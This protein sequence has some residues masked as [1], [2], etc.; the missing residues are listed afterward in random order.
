M[1][2]KNQGLEAGMGMD[3]GRHQIMRPARDSVGVDLNFG[4]A[5]ILLAAILATSATLHG[6][7]S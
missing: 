1:R 6:C 3:F 5:A 4:L 7:H 2:F